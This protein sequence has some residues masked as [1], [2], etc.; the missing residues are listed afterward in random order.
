[1]KRPCHGIKST[2]PKQASTRATQLVPQIAIGP[3]PAMNDALIHNIF[4]HHLLPHLI[5][6]N[7]NKLIANVFCFGAFADCHSGIV[8]N[9]ITGNFPFMSFNGS[10]CYLV[11]YHYKLNAIFATSITGVDDVSIF[12][13]CKLNFD[14]LTQKGYK[15]KLNL[16][17][18]QVTSANCSWL[19]LT[20]T[21]STPLNMPSK[22]S[23]MGSLL[24]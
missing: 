20:I 9:D 15:P 8:Y 2:Q 18:N 21:E 11:M 24:C 12:N 7:C 13:A 6:N 4:Q 19:N 3:P 5:D 23:K 17:D 22:H 16:M 14:E 1:M 10:M